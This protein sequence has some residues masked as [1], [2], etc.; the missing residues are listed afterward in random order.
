[1]TKNY[2]DSSIIRNEGVRLLQHFL[3]NDYEADF[4][5]SKSLHPLSP[6]SECAGCEVSKLC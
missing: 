4:N 3:K 6:F 5:S 1:M 2:L